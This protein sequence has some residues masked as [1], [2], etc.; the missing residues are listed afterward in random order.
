[1]TQWNAEIMILDNDGVYKKEEHFQVNATSKEEAATKAKNMSQSW[2]KF[3]EGTAEVVLWS[4]KRRM[5][6]RMRTKDNDWSWFVVSCVRNVIN[7]PK[8]RRLWN[9]MNILKAGIT[10]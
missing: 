6:Y 9:T 5:I 10:T 1:M 4:N 8:R 7:K 2:Y 3:F